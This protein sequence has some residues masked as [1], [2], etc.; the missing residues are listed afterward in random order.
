MS[1]T[2]NDP[3]EPLGLFD[4]K[5]VVESIME[6]LHVPSW[7]VRASDRPWLQPGR[8][9]E[10]LVDDEVVGWIGEVHPRVLDAYEAEGPV[11]LFE[12]SV[13]ALVA[14]AVAVTPYEEVPRFPSAN[15]DVSLTLPVDV[16]VEQVEEVM[17]D[18]GKGIL[19]TARLFDVYTGKGV[20]EGKRSLAFSLVYRSQA[21]TLT[22]EEVQEAHR[23]IVS[24][25][26]SRLGAEIRS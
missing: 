6:E 16:T 19:E 22:D 24:E 18:A 7:T 21:R 23:R 3:G 5:G 20:P 2:W 11:T 26:G 8:G 25:V 9:T 17:H 13:P 1:Q 10:I 14:A 15:L 12:M 4:G